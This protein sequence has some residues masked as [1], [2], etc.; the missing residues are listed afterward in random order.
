V[1]G[2]P[3]HQLLAALSYGDAV[4]NHALTIQAA[5]RRA[6]YASDIF[7]EH[8]H[9]RMTQ[10]VR[11]YWEYPQVSSA[12]TV[13]LFHF[14]I[15]S[16]ASPLIYHLPDT[17]VA[18]YHNITPPEYFVGFRP[19]LVGL[20]Y[21]A[22]RELAM[23]VPR[24]R[25]ALGVSE[26]NRRELAAMGFGE[27][28]VLPIV[29]EWSAYERAG[30]RLTRALYDDDRT[31]IVFVGRIS[32]NKCID[33]L[34]RTFACYQRYV[35]PRS[36]LLLVGDHRGYEK[37][38]DRLQEMVQVLR[39]EE[40]VFTGHVVRTTSPHTTSW[41]IS[42]CASPSTRAMACR[43]SRRWPPVSPSWPMT[44]APWRRRCAA[45]ACWSRRRVPKSWPR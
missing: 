41:V 36:R 40:V 1:S 24:T 26:F 14:S 33:D 35:N 19:H 22:R 2:R 37:Y 15:G 45:R 38:Y 25:L 44:P 12:E 39:V 28:G 13:C 20:T 27:T 23:F 10:Y 3:I 8:V 6:G 43:C 11:P 30:S 7:V 16:A 42:S 9:P 34:V 32:P 17:L 5:L 29:P 31:N 18:I 4:S 21:H